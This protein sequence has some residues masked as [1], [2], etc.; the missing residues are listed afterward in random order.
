MSASP[1]SGT[2]ATVVRLRRGFIARTMNLSIAVAPEELDLPAARRVLSSFVRAV[3]AG[4]FGP[5]GGPVAAQP[6]RTVHQ[7]TATIHVLEG[8]FPRLRPDAFGTLERMARA[9]V[10]CGRRLEIRERAPETTLVVRG[11]ERDCEV[12][13][14]DVP[15]RISLPLAADPAVRV[16]FREAPNND[17]AA[18]TIEALCAWTDVVALGG[19]PGGDTRSSSKAK[20]REVGRTSE[21]EI[22]LRFEHF[23]CAHDGVEALFEM[24]CTVNEHASIEMV[25]VGGTASPLA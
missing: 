10:S 4:M 14:P 19:F 8:A 1:S 2:M 20:L 22:E 9:S 24:L 11:F 7:Q 12:T 5:V 6:I 21:R 17:V 15:W 3:D 23:S 18:A 13:I 16:V 25:E